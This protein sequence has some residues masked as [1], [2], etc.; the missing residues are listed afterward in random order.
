MRL[1]QRQGHREAAA[2]TEFALYVDRPV[3]RLDDSA[4]DHQAQADA[5]GG[6]RTARIAAEKRLENPRLISGGD[7]DAVVDHLDHE[8]RAIVRSARAEHHRTFRELTRVVE[9]VVEHAAQH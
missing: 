3:V 1:R 8:T 7:T 5:T 2:R 6:A 9:Q 4:H